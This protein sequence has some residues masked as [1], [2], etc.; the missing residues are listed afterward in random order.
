MSFG[1]PSSNQHLWTPA[2]TINHS[3]S[4]VKLRRTPIKLQ[5]TTVQFFSQ[6][7]DVVCLLLSLVFLLF[8]GVKI[9]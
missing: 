7:F 3:P 5:N 9:C 2:T 6:S 4:P 8:G 1:E